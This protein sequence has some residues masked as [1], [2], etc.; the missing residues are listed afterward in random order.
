VQALLENGHGQTRLWIHPR[1]RKTIESLE[2]QAYDDK[3]LPDKETGHDHMADALGYVVHR[4]YAVERGSAGRVVR[5]MRRV[6]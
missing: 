2:L 6:Y 5:G 4:R 3:G 1:C